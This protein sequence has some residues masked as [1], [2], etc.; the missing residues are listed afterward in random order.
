MPDGTTPFGKRLKS[1]GDPWKQF[2]DRFQQLIADTESKDLQNVLR[3]MHQLSTLLVFLECGLQGT[4]E[5]MNDV[6]GAIDHLR[7]STSKK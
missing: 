2:D 7:E 3:G 4:V 1:A 6:R 5:A